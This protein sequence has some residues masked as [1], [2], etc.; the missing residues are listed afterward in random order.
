MERK[1]LKR[2]IKGLAAFVLAVVMM[3]GSSISALA[4]SY[5]YE[6]VFHI[7]RDPGKLGNSFQ[8][9]G[10]AGVSRHESRYASFKGR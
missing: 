4:A 3:F 6:V 9:G 2:R 5:I 7:S 1:V 8:R 10:Q